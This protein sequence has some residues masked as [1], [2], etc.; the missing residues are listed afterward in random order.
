MDITLRQLEYVMA[1]A[2]TKNFSSAAQDCYVTQPALSKQIHL[3]EKT[4]GI[5]LFERQQKKQVVITPQGEQVLKLSK[6]IMEKASQIEKIGEGHADPLNGIVKLGV[7]PTIAP[8]FIP[9]LL[10]NLREDYPDTQ[11]FIQEGLTE[12]LVARTIAGDLDACL[13]ATE[14]QLKSLD[15]KDI[16]ED[17]FVALLKE[18]DSLHQKDELSPNDLLDEEIILLT[19][20]HCLKDQT[21]SLCSNIGSVEN[22]DLRATSLAT[23]VELVSL[24]FGKTI[25]PKLSLKRELEGKKGLKVI[26]FT[27][28]KPSRTIGLS[29]RQGSPFRGAIPRL[30]S[31]ILKSV[32]DLK[33]TSR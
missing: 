24:G 16:F 30:E 32:D 7:I 5:K 20:G 31:H 15:S 3:L 2:K 10:S 19:D 27:H 17:E 14:A 28:Q 29:W 22:T 9:T 18:N 21:L 4:I 6:E 33:R 8:Y 11:F 1:L 23:I 26:P 13:L 25:L 12:E